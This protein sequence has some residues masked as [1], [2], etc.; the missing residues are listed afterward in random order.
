[1][2]GNYSKGKKNNKMETKISFKE[3]VKNMVTEDLKLVKNKV[4]NSILNEFKFFR[5]LILKV[6]NKGKYNQIK[7]NENKKNIEFYNSNIQK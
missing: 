7:N 6:F 2:L 3:L 4:T 5:E 1:M